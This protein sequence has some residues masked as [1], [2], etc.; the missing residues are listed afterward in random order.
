MASRLAPWYSFCYVAMGASWICPGYAQQHVPCYYVPYVPT[1]LLWWQQEAQ[2]C[3]DVLPL[4]YIV[5][6]MSKTETVAAG[7]LLHALSMEHWCMVGWWDGGM[8]VSTFVC[9]LCVGD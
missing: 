6:D 8:V 4:Y 5:G 3:Q 9:T 2:A 7:N 1:D